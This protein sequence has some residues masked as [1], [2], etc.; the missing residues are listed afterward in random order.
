MIQHEKFFFF[1]YTV[2]LPLP[3]IDAIESIM[4]GKAGVNELQP[5]HFDF[6]DVVVTIKI[7]ST[8]PFRHY[9]F[10]MT[11]LSDYCMK[12]FDVWG[13]RII[14]EHAKIVKWE[15]AWKQDK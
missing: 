7:P 2:I 9:L 15:D 11:Q 3:K 4:K 14:A 1:R 5:G 6:Q 13:G 12:E 10:W 8:E